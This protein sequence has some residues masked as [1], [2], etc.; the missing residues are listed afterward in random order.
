M[1]DRFMFFGALMVLFLAAAAGCSGPFTGSRPAGMTPAQ[2]TAQDVS[3]ATFLPNPL[4][5]ANPAMASG[6]GTTAD[7]IRARVGDT[8]AISYNGT[9]QNG[10]VFD[11]NMDAKPVEFTL[12]NRS[13]IDGLNEAID[14]MAEG[15][16][17]TVQI[18]AAKAYGDYNASLVWT[19]NRTGP[20]ANTSFVAGKYY[21]IHNK[22]TNSFSF[23]K[24]LDITPTTVT[25]DGNNPLAGMNFTFTIRLVKITRP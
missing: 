15:E 10:T 13:I 14:G 22:E 8:V 5:A 18:P 3:S 24:V 7:G 12:G 2:T 19:V 23:V 1:N 16:V 11:S 25:L 17:K 20:L 6:Q 21:S 4:S 9:F